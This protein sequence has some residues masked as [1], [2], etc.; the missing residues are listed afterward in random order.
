MHEQ[1]PMT[2]GSV[3]AGSEDWDAQLKWLRRVVDVL[4][5]KHIAGELDIAPSTLTDA[6]LE[7]ERKA[8][9]GEWIAKIVRMSSP[10]LREEWLSI[11]TE[12]Y[13]YEHP[14]RRPTM[15]PE[16][17]LRLLKEH[18]TEDSPGALNRFNRRIGRSEVVAIGG[19]R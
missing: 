13:D 5:H 19:G 9:K 7:R 10:G 1:L 8:M 18:L 17:E 11:W 15:T 12:A 3:A 6:L 14:K 4:G 16:D 2:Y